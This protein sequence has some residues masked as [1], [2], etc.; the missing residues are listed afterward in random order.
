RTSGVAI[1]YVSHRL[2]ELS[3]IADR[4]TVLRDG[5]WI[6]TRP[7]KGM[8]TGE[9]I[10]AMVGREVAAIFPK[11]VVPI[12][13]ER[14]RTRGLASE[15]AGIRDVSISVRAGE[16]LGIAGL[17]GAG[18][19]E[20]AQVLFGLHPADLGEIAI[21]GQPVA[22]NSPAAAIE[23]K[24]AYVPE[25]RRVH[26]VIPEM[27]VAANATLALLEGNCAT[28]V[29]SPAGALDFQA[30]ENLAEQMVAQLHIKTASVA[31]PVETLSGGNQQKVALARWLA[32]GPRVLILDEPT[33][34]IDVGAKSEIHRLMVDLAE[35][36]LAIIVISS[37]LPELLGMCD[38][39][40]V[41]RSGTISG[42]LSREEVTAEGIM[43]LALPQ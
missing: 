9:L 31:S 14:L 15:A 24:I 21:D 34:G 18:R 29:A 42:T 41:M 3:A 35:Q 2:E 37:E 40:A 10:S 12:G 38:R 4:V 7:M 23:R 32:T 20:L 17:M 33:Q 36:G 30:E 16:I 6:A 22:I 27:S 28:R 8:Q 43:T 19:T 39:I 13:E 1:L 25:D 11:R 5:T 26:G